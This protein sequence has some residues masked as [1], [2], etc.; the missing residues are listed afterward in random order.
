MPGSESTSKICTSL[1]KSISKIKGNWDMAEINSR[2]KVL[3]KHAVTAWPLN[4]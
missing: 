4:V 2:Q 1:T 3:A